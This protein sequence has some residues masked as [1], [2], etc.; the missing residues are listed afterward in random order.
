MLSPSS[1]DNLVH[2]SADPPLAGCRILVAEDEALIALELQSILEDFGC[3]V[4]GP[5]SSVDEVLRNAE[6]GG[7]DGALLDINLRDRQIFEIL[8]RLDKLGMKLIITSGYNDVTLFPAAFRSLS[9]ISKPFDE[10]ELRLICEN[11]FGKGATR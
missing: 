1:K 9:R 6:R 5:F 11:V 4:V 2:R 10:K 8:P 3:E 7:F